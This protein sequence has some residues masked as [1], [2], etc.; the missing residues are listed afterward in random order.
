MMYVYYN[1]IHKKDPDEF[2]LMLFF[3]NHCLFLSSL[4]LLAEF[5]SF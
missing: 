5:N 4:L 1:L 2:V 3:D